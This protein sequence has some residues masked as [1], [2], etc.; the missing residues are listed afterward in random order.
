MHTEKE[1]REAKISARD[2]G[3]HELCI[4]MYTRTALTCAN[5]RRNTRPR[6]TFWNLCFMYFHRSL[7]RARSISCLADF[8]RL[9]RI[10]T[11][12]AQVSTL[13]RARVSRPSCYSRRINF[14]RVL[15][16]ARIPLAYIIHLNP[17][18]SNQGFAEKRGVR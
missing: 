17:A 7:P 10:V 6:P 15:A 3:M 1:K 11:R 13:W 9:A 8:L 16:R 4:Y 18:D 5:A 2:A 12:A 14:Q